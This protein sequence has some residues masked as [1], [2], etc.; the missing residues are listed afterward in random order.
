[1]DWIIVPCRVHYDGMVP[2]RIEPLAPI[3]VGRIVREGDSIFEIDEYEQRTGRAW[4][5]E[6]HWAL[7]SRFNCECG[8]VPLADQRSPDLKRDGPLDLRLC[9]Y[10]DCGREMWLSATRSTLPI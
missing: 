3:Y 6:S 7:F 8:G 9:V 5:R 2:T 10:C 4:T 1:V